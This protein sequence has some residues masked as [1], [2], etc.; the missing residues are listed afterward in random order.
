[1]SKKLNF[2]R[3]KIENSNFNYKNE[4]LEYRKSQLT[5][6]KKKQNFNINNF[7]LDTLIS[8]LDG[9]YKFFVKKNN[10]IF[11]IEN[12]DISKSIC[13]TI[14]KSF[15]INIL[16]NINCSKSSKF[17]K[18]NLLV[19]EINQKDN[20]VL[21][22]ITGDFERHLTNIND[23]EVEVE[24]DEEDEEAHESDYNSDYNELDEEEELKDIDY[25]NDNDIILDELEELEELEEYEH[26]SDEEDTPLN[27]NKTLIYIKDNI[28]KQ[29]FSIDN[30]YTQLYN[31]RQK[32]IEIFQK[33]LK[34]MNTIRKI[35]LSVINYSIDK[36]KGQNI[37]PTWENPNFTYIYINKCRHI[38]LNLDQKSYIK[39][40]YL[41]KEIKKKEFDLL[42]IAYLKREEI[43]PSIWMPLIEENK[44]KEE[45]MNKSQTAEATDQYVCPNRNCRARKSLYKEVQTRSAD[46]PMTLF[47]TCLVCGKKWKF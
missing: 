12:K 37:I 8:K 35:E 2:L 36:C 31:T 47:L 7:I 28:I 9:K 21:D 10:H 17:K 6:A 23:E 5:I 14:E 34:D 24:D 38:Y 16:E 44:R 30:D 13:E 42:K 45:I 41:I 29:E 46:E 18:T 40:D 39:N 3:I 20:T 11:F 25:E 26:I 43:M 4:K 15:N 33:I 22:L 32:T 27:T 19:F 1:M